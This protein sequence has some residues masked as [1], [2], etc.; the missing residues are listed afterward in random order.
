M[1]KITFSDSFIT[2]VFSDNGYDDYTGILDLNHTATNGHYTIQVKM[3]YTSRPNERTYT[4]INGIYMENP[5]AIDFAFRLALHKSICVCA[6]ENSLMDDEDNLPL[7]GTT[8]EGLDCVISLEIQDKESPASTGQKPDYS[9]YRSEF[10]VFFSRELI[11]FFRGN[12]P[13]LKKVYNNSMLETEALNAARRAYYS[14][15]YNLN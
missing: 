10:E 3:R 15:K 11:K 2:S 14:A 6:K 7:A 5:T 4:F 1:L 12:L 8:R 9:E 13:I